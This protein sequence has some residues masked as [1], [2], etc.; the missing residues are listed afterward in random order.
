MG[1]GC[2][3]PYKANRFD[4]S[5]AVQIVGDSMAISHELSSE[6]AAA[7]F[8]AKE[9]SPQELKDLKEILLLIHST[10]QRLTEDAR[11]DRAHRLKSQSAYAQIAR[12]RSASS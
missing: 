8:V 7:L 4:C 5:G 3:V 9:R 2:D 12:G 11:V 10:L 1:V 6:I